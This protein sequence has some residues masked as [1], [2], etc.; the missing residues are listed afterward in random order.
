MEIIG[1]E[2]TGMVYFFIIQKHIKKRFLYMIIKIRTVLAIILSIL[3]L[4]TATKTY[5]LPQKMV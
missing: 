3:F 4:K 5:G 1:Q 2:V